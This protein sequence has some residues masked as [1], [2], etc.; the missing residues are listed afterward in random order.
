M[1]T[2]LRPPSTATAPSSRAD[3]HARTAR[4]LAAS[5]VIAAVGMLALNQ[6]ADAA[7][8][9]GAQSG[10]PVCH[11][12]DEVNATLFPKQ[13]IVAYDFKGD[14]A[15]RLK[16]AMDGVSKNRAPVASLVRLVL[17]LSTDEAFAFQFGADG[18][19]T[20][21]VVLDVHGMA[22]VFENAGVAAPFGATFYQLTG[23]AI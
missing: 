2:N 12:V 13:Q 22:S 4:Y 6:R 23:R 10:G 11:K 17:V 8:L 19:R 1:R 15:G 20:N 21:T 5:L 7:E 16:S 18:C 14:D 9:Y 3:G